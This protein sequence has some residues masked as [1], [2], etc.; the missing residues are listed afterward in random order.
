MLYVL[1]GVKQLKE[2]GVKTIYV[3]PCGD[4]EGTRIKLRQTCMHT[5]LLIHK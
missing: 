2:A 4:P 1:A 5:F 3:D